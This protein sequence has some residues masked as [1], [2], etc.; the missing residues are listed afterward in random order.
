MTPKQY[1]EACIYAVRRFHTDIVLE[2][3]ANRYGEV[4]ETEA[5]GMA[6]SVLQSTLMNIA[7]RIEDVGERQEFIKQAWDD[8]SPA[9]Q[10]MRHMGTIR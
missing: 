7:I 4:C 10:F 2:Y 6:A 1:E 5:L 3:A 9:G 8:F